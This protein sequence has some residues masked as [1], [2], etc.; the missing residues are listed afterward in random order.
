MIE[1]QTTPSRRVTF[2]ATA[3]DAA[4]QRGDGTLTVVLDAAWTPEPGGRPDVVSIRPSFA[5]VLEAHD[6]YG[7]SLALLDRWA[8]DAGLADLLVVEGITYWY[9]MREPLWNWVHERLL[10]RYALEAIDP[11]GSHD[12]ASVPWAE[13][14]LIDILGALGWTV[15]VDGSPPPPADPLPV[16]RRSSNPPLPSALRRLVRRVIPRSGSAAAAARR[17]HLAVLDERFDRLSRLAGPRVFVLTLPSS[18]QRIGGTQAARAARQDP[19]LGSVIP[20]LRGAGLEPIVIGWGMTRGREDEDWPIVEA[21]DRLLPA[22]YLAARGTRPGDD[23][24]AT[25]AVEGVLTR[26]DALSTIPFGLDGLDLAPALVE[27]LRTVFQRTIEADVRELARVERLF[28]ELRPGAVLTTQEAHRTPWLLAGARAGVPTFALQHGVLYPGHPGYPNRRHPML[29]LPSRTFV[30]GEY[31]RR[32]LETLAYRPDEVA[33]SGSPRLDLD[34][35]EV[36][37]STI[38]GGRAAVRAELGVAE[39]DLL[40]VVSTVHVPFV[41]RSH[42]VHMLE[43]LLGGPLPGV[44]IVFKQHPGEGDA[45]P[46]RALLEG[47]ARAGGYPPPPMTV[48]KD[49]DLYRLLRAADAHLG[50][51]STVL[52]DAVKAGTR[53]LIATVGPGGDILGYVEA[54]VAR[55]IHDIAELREALREPRSPDPAAR[56]AFLDDHFRP[57]DAGSRIAVAIQTAARE[58]SSTATAGRPRC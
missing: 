35:G 42:L 28:E 11:A 26:L 9:R 54:G 44:H 33:V 38:D 13:T 7:E 23:A 4:V 16:A 34:G 31:E 24:R 52:T 50:Q 29:I 21:D 45:G 41:R 57:G 53:N 43:A 27:T 36:G 2:V 8:D 18:Y 10:W 6:L 14:A 30:F 37:A 1:T 48:V 22:W 49:I 47:L 3:A 20:A 32:V 55:P 5:V 15:E 58:P 19:N 46:Y 12:A 56:Q 25:A 39:G 51:L 40:L 17:R